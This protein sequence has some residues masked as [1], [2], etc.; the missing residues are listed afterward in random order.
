MQGF[1]R[2]ILARFGAFIYIHGYNVSSGPRF[3][4]SIYMYTLGYR[5]L[6]GTF[7]HGLVLLSTYLLGYSVPIWHF[8]TRYGAFIYIL[9]YRVSSDTFPGMGRYFLR[10]IMLLPIVNSLNEKS[11]IL[12]NCFAYAVYSKKT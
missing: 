8:P 3:G 6:S 10:W 7:H 4:S 1:I 11:H 9:G 5:V 2:H 12:Q